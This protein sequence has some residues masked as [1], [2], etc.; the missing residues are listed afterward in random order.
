M[1]TLI[2]DSYIDTELDTSTGFIEPLLNHLLNERE[3]MLAAVTARESVW[4]T[5]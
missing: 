5:R 3:L 4:R 1:D 2:D